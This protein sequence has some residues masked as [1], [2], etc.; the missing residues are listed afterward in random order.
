MLFV[1]GKMMQA[2][3]H[4]QP[5]P[6]FPA[7]AYGGKAALTLWVVLKAQLGSVSPTLL[8]EGVRALDQADTT[9]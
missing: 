7:G 5:A 8:T 3:D 9:L 2:G 1:S 6:C 4:A